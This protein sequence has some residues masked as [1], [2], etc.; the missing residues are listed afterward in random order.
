M[1]VK[2]VFNFIYIRK[3]KGFKPYKRPLFPSA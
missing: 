1:V 2:S 3:I